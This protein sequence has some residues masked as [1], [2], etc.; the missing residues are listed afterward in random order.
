MAAMIAIR[1]FAR[2]EGCSHTAVQNAIRDGY[3]TALPNGKLDPALVGTGWRKQPRKP[4][5]D[6]DATVDAA[7]TEAAARMLARIGAPHSAAEAERIKENYLAFLR[8]LEYDQ[9]SA[10]VVYRVD[11]AAAAGAKFAKVRTKLMAIP[12]EWAARIHRC[13][14]PAEVQDVLMTAVV[15]ALEELSG[16]DAPPG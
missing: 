16:G 11:A 4:P 13:K 7:A 3:L 2:R 12:A 5:S 14:S 9:K 6:E 15:H 1:E 8:Q 10:A